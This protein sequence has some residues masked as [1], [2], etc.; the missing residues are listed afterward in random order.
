MMQNLAPMPTQRNPKIPLKRSSNATLKLKS[1]K[2]TRS[3]DSAIYL[4]HFITKSTNGASCVTHA[5]PHLLVE[6]LGV[7]GGGSDVG[8][9]GSL[10][11][12]SLLLELLGGLQVGRAGIFVGLLVLAGLAD[13]VF[14][15]GGKEGEHCLG[16]ENPKDGVVASIVLRRGYPASKGSG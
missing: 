1:A 5:Q 11:G 6:R 14:D 16:W 2:L 4:H 9:A 12:A 10:V 7:G 15:R 3:S 13:E 8:I